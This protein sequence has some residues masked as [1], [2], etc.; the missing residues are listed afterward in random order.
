MIY[1]VYS[2]IKGVL[3]ALGRRPSKPHRSLIEPFKEPCKEPFKGRI[4]SSR[5]PS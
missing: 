2:L 1:K 3:E 5:L 4:P